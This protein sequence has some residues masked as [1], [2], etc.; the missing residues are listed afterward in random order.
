MLVRKSHEARLERQAMQQEQQTPEEKLRGYI[1]RLAQWVFGICKAETPAVSELM[2][3]LR[4]IFL[5]ER[6]Q[7]TTP[8]LEEMVYEHL[9][10]DTAEIRDI[11]RDIIG[12]DAPENVVRDCDCSIAAQILYYDTHWS[13]HMRLNPDRP[14]MH[15]Y[16]ER[17]VDHITRFSLAGIEATK[18]ALEE[19]KIERGRDESSNSTHSL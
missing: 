18:K 14:S 2:V 7:A 6:T 1:M 4:K 12:R 5:M 17:L 3:D 13:I 9:R 15:E 16:L 8:E 10:E 19:G 11:I